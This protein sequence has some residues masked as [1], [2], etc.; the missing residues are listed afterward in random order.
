[1]HAIFAAGTFLL[2]ILFAR[3]GRQNDRNENEENPWEI[4]EKSPVEKCGNGGTQTHYSG[5]NL[6]DKE[7]Y[8]VSNGKETVAR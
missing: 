5:Y 6:M 8:I 3:K 4:E 2:A 7:N 1:L